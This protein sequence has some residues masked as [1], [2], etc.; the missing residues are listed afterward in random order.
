MTA[1]VHC[2]LVHHPVRDRAGHPI[3]SAITNVDVHDLARSARTFGLAGYWVVSPIAAQRLLVERILDHWAH[4]AGARR[5]PERTRALSICAPIESVD[6]AIAAIT[7]REGSAPALWVTA[8]KAPPGKTLTSWADGR[9]LLASSARPVLILFGTAHGLHSTLMD[10]A[11]VV[12]APIQPGSDYN[13][14]S[15]RAAAAITFDRLLGDR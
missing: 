3:A 8:A 6:A 5:V 10:R 13:H 1:R 14:L 15:V 4:G 11:D 12:L 7:E 9:A 2:A